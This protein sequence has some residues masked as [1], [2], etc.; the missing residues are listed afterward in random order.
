MPIG[1]STGLGYLGR[2]WVEVGWYL[3]RS[4]ERWSI[5]DLAGSNQGLFHVHVYDLHL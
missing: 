4:G 1:C 3:I 5:L 2:I